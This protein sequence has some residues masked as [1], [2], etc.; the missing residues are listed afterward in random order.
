M[1][2]VRTVHDRPQGGLKRPDA[3]HQGGHFY[4]AATPEIRRTAFM[5]KRVRL[6]SRDLRRDK[7]SSISI[8]RSL[9]RCDRRWK[10]HISQVFVWF[11]Q[12]PTNAANFPKS[13]YVNPISTLDKLHR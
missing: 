8:I 9:L 3:Y 4:L 1:P 11:H 5:L 7:F 13:Q 12:L 2:P 6:G 10:S